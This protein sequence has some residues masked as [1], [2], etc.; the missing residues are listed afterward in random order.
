PLT[1]AEVDI[2]K[3]AGSGLSE[4]TKFKL[5][6]FFTGNTREQAEVD[7]AMTVYRNFAQKCD[8]ELS[9][10]SDIKEKGRK[11]HGLFF[12]E[13][14]KKQRMEGY[15]SSGISGLL[16]KK[17]YDGNTANLLFSILSE[18]YGFIPEM[19][20]TEGDVAQITSKKTNLSMKILTG[21]V[22][23]TLRH[24]DMPEPVSIFTTWENGYD[25]KIDRDFFE[26]LQKN[27]PDTAKSA[28]IEFKRYN[29]G[30]KASLNETLMLQYKIDKAYEVL[31]L[32][33]APGY[34]R[35][36]MAA[37]LTDSCEVLID[38]AWVWRDIYGFLFPVWKKGE[39]KPF[40]DFIQPG[41][42]NTRQKCENDSKFKQVAG[43]LYLFSA[44]EYA[45]AVDGIRMK[46]TIKNAYKYIDT[47]SKDYQNDKNWLVGSVH[48]YLNNV[49]KKDVIDKEVDNINEIIGSIPEHGTKVEVAASFYYHA[50][51]YYFSKSDFWKAAQ[52]YSNCTG[53][54]ENEYKKTCG[55]NGAV[56]FYNYAV[57]SLNENNCTKA[58]NGKDKCFE[59]FP[60][61][62]YCNKTKELVES[63]CK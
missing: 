27:N 6:L 26:N 58:E 22:Y 28:D 11:L 60:G 54:G 47:A 59:K 4:E 51:Q 43:N 14:I 36:E 25:L 53:V 62:D 12:S 41:L 2:L 44:S 61:D 15:Q 10:I 23:L 45:K 56:S 18:R 29:N 30:I 31:D 24:P 16:I 37:Q 38:R 39:I 55:P 63:N 8:Q 13:F 21:R 34:R 3:E 50:G 20:L 1:Q 52:F 19:L 5:A 7:S 17:E 32:E 40:I 9:K 42:E 35:T 48:E 57:S 49:I 46:K 33:F